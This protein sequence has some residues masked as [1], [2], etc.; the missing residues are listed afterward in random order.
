MTALVSNSMIML[1]ACYSF[2]EPLFDYW[3]QDSELS[4]HYPHT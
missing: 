3:A 2:L 4:G 1:L